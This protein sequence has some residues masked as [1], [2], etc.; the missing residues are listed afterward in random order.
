LRLTQSCIS[1]VAVIAELQAL[2]PGTIRNRAHLKPL[3]QV[4]PERRRR[5][6]TCHHRAL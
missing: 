3:G 2:I 6:R 1:T 4:A 5:R